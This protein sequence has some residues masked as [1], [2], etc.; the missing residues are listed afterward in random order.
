MPGQE[1]QSKAAP[2]SKPS[3]EFFECPVPKC[4]VEKRRDKLMEHI[5]KAVKYDQNGKALNPV[6]GAFATLDFTEK[7]HTEFFHKNN[8]NRKTSIKD[9]TSGQQSRE[10]Q[11]TPV[12][13]PFE[14]AARA[15]AKK[16][17]IQ[18]GSGDASVNPK[19]RLTLPD[20]DPD[21]PQPGC[22]S[23]NSPVLQQ[24]SGLPGQVI[25]NLQEKSIYRAEPVYP[26]L[27]L[28]SFSSYE[29]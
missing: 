17:Q 10:K 14:L 11:K 22:S 7:I 8:F 1:G 21:D 20:E 29:K 2:S 19:R 15:S 9:I 12:L 3:R 23:W 24:E 6:S 26:F 27:A 5:S 13:S 28:L 4:K 18:S 25:C 16:R